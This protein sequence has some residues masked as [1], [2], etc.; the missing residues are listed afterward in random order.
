M[1]QHLTSG[2]DGQDGGLMPT[3]WSPAEFA[4]A[5]RSI[6]EHHSGHEAHRHLDLITSELLVSLGYGDGIA[7]FCRAVQGWHHPQLAY[8]LRQRPRLLCRIGLHY[9][10]ADL[11]SDL[12]WVSHEICIGCNKRRSFNPCP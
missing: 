6:V 3:H 12:P 11:E 9:W 5:C 8:P 2:T 4:D 10:R 7:V 1:T